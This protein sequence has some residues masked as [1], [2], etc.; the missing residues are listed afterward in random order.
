M[1]GFMPRMICAAT[2]TISKKK[3]KILWTAD[4]RINCVHVHDV[5]RAT[6][7][8]LENGKK[9]DIYNLSDKS[10]MNQGKFN[11]FLEEIFNIKTT[12]LGSMLS[13]VAKL[14]MKDATEYANEIHM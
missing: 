5:V 8:L 9:G 4:L 6:W 12:F 3:M 1:N 14:K 13:N 2:Y 11:K 7:H 10:D